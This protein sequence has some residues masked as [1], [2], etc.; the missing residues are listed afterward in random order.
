MLNS[1]SA[2]IKI[3]QMLEKRGAHLYHAC[4]VIQF[5]DYLKRGGVPPVN[6]NKQ[7]F[8]RLSFLDKAALFAKDSYHLPDA[9]GP[10]TLQFEP[11]ILEKAESVA[12]FLVPAT[13]QKKRLPHALSID[14]IPYLFRY[15]EDAPMPE[16]SYIKSEEALGEAFETDGPQNPQ[17]F[18]TFPDNILPLDTI[19]DVVVDNYLMKNRQLRDWVKAYANHFAREITVRRRYCPSD[20]GGYLSDRLV[21]CLMD[22]LPALAELAQDK[23]QFMTEWA[24]SLIERGLQKEFEDFAKRLREETLLPLLEA[25][26]QIIKKEK[27]FLAT[28][29]PLSSFSTAERNLIDKLYQEKLPAD[30]IARITEIEEGMI[31]TYLDSK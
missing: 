13:S 20:I 17:L 9:N 27:V 22:R 11:A 15:T 25:E 4:Q 26:P 31:K 24:Q 2:K 16:K 5:A 29:D 6:Q 10:L 18:I 23:D 1:E 3:I 21:V 19:R 28:A 12:P 14:D 8:I 7:H 30:A